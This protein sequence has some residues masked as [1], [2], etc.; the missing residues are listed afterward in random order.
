MFANTV[1]IS[2]IRIAVWFSGCDVLLIP[3]VDG[4]LNFEKSF[5]GDDWEIVNEEIYG[6]DQGPFAIG[7]RDELFYGVMCPE[8]KPQPLYTQEE[9]ERFIIQSHIARGQMTDVFNQVPEWIEQ[10]VKKHER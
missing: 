7:V 4:E 6:Y 9:V 10:Y 8:F 2:D 5:I 1:I 3:I